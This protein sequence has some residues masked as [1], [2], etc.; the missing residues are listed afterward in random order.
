[1]ASQKLLLLGATGT[2]GVNT[3]DV[4]ARHPD[5]FSVTGLAAG[6]NIDLLFK[7]ACAH[8]PES[9]IICDDTALSSWQKGGYSEKLRHQLGYSPDLGSV[10]DLHR[11]CQSTN[12]DT[13]VAA[14]VGSAGLKPT[15]S[16]LQAG[17]KV[18]LANKESLVLAGR[19]MI[20]AC[21]ESGATIL[22]VDSEH[23][24]IYQCLPSNYDLSRPQEFGIERMILTA[25]GGPF[26]KKSLAELEQVTPA[27][28]VAH[29]NWVMGRKI[30]VD[31]STM[32]NKGLE[33]IEALWLFGLPAT[34]LSVLVHP[35]SIVHSLVEYKD[36][37]MLA[38]LGCPDMRTPIAHV[39][40]L[41]DR[42]ESGSPRLNLAQLARLHFEEPDLTRFPMLKLAFEVLNKPDTLAPVFNAANEI[43]VD[44]FLNEKISYM[45]IVRL[46]EACLSRFAGESVRGLDDAFAL[47]NTVRVYAT[48]CVGKL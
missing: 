3:L 35:E 17:K 36:G 28:A 8:R 48:E 46:T 22:P 37:S 29:P 33:L 41:P 10:K 27:Q 15:L 14:I 2:I 20:K 1:M 12:V 24:A 30:S 16:A 21:L 9:L 44:L 40:G 38:Q 26:R 31:S 7:Q 11:V 18:L 25:S 23:N 4:V 32:A 47:D 43:A 13:V 6:K 39:L 45:D 42:I 19:F 5:R 34:Q